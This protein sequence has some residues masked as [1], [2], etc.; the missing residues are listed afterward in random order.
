[1]DDIVE[2]IQA[3][4]GRPGVRLFNGFWDGQ[5]ENDLLRQFGLHVHDRPAGLR[6]LEKNKEK[7]ANVLREHLNSGP[8]AHKLAAR[9]GSDAQHGSV[10]REPY[11]PVE[12][13]S[14]KSSF[15]SGFAVE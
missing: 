6:L 1:M 13:W 8:P 4:M 7:L 3:R 9:F 5:D 11:F 2:N 10:S 15:N 14:E 12:S